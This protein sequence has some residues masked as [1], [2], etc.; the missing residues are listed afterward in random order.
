[1][2]YKLKVVMKDK[3]MVILGLL[4]IQRIKNMASMI[5]KY[6]FLTDR[7]TMFYRT[8]KS[9]GDKNEYRKFI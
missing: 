1:M 3:T 8:P 5:V 7:N 2:P 4:T 6:M 9:K